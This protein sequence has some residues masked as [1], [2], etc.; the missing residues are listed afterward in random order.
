MSEDQAK[1]HLEKW[2]NCNGWRT[3]IHWG[4]TRG[5]D[6]LA[7]TV[8]ERWV[9]EV[10]G[11]GTSQQMQLNYFLAILGEIIQRIDSEEVK[12]SIA[13]P[14]LDRYRTLWNNLSDLVKARLGVTLL[15]VSEEGEISEIN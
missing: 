13:L 6:I 12:Y 9:V 4:H 14:N 1:Q 10:K 3:E 11:S 15:L 8:S 7:T 2:F 5:V